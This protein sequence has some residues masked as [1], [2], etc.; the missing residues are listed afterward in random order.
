M[1]KKNKKQKF[2]EVESFPNF[3]Q[4]GY[5]DIQDNGFPLKGKWNKE[6]FKNDN[7]IIAEF[8]CGKGDYTYNLA[9]KNPNKNYIG[10]DL[11]GNRIWKG[12]KDSIK[13]GLSNVAFV[14]GQVQHVQE[15]FEPGELSEIWITFPDPQ[16]E[17]PRHRKRFTHPAFLERYRNILAQDHLIHLKTDSDVFFDYTLEILKE[18]GIEPIICSYDVYTDPEIEEN[19]P[20]VKEI[21]TFYER[22]WL[23]EG[24]LIKYL[25]FCLNPTNNG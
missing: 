4:P 16:L 25:R 12:A 21:Q 1:G 23:A 3:F 17:K 2:A 13:D 24:R 10:M 18:E 22:M 6:Y 19:A 5:F 20:E 9:K 11:K 8:G 7:P 14:R 15:Y